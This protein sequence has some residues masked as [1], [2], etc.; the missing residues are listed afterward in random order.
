M[1]WGY[2]SQLPMSLTA[3]GILS[4]SLISDESPAI[5]F[6]LHCC[7]SQW[8]ALKNTHLSSLAEWEGNFNQWTD[9]LIKWSFT[10]QS[11]RLHPSTLPV[12]H[13]PIWWELNLHHNRWRHHWSLW[14][15]LSS[16]LSPG[17]SWVCSPADRCLH[18]KL[19]LFHLHFRS[20]SLEVPGGSR[21]QQYSEISTTIYFTLIQ[22][23]YTRHGW[24]CWTVS[25]NDPDQNQ[26]SV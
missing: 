20:G 25:K 6:R 10:K 17:H 5:A 18:A 13:V 7:I 26:I 4:P 24:D 15:M 16:R 8:R 3:T 1:V 23:M 2:T 9:S 21:Q 11:F 14:V 19:E 22:V 12:P